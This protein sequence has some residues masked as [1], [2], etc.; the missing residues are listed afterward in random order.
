MTLLTKKKCTPCS[1]ETKPLEGDELVAYETNLGNNWK[2]IN[3]HHLEKEYIF[4]D[5][6]TALAFTNMVGAIAEAEGH[7]PNI[8]LAWG[9]V[10][11]VIWTHAINGLSEND[12]IIAAKCDEISQDS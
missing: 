3:E 1:K 6:K 5:F 7:H 10:R 9:R 12:F 4:K 11:L 8:H 2:V